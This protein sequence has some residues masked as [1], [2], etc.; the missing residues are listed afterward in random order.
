MGLGGFVPGIRTATSIGAQV[1]GW[2]DVH[3]KDVMVLF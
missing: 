1:R 2:V 3:R